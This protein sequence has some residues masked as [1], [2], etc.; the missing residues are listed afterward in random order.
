MP[1]NDCLRKFI[2]G[3]FIMIRLAIVV[4]FC[5]AFVYLI[6]VSIK[7]IKFIS[8]HFSSIW[9]YSSHKGNEVNFYVAVCI[10]IIMALF[11]LLDVLVIIY[12][13]IS[14]RH[15]CSAI[16]NFSLI[17][18]NFIK[19]YIYPEEVQDDVIAGLYNEDAEKIRMT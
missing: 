13:M 18:V 19:D 4:I 3:I 15:F 9:D 7:T 5:F 12:A 10:A 14:A 17:F 2:V 1:T 6:D 16:K 11:L 8:R